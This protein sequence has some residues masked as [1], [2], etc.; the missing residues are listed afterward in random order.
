MREALVIR[1]VFLTLWSER[2]AIKSYLVFKWIHLLELL[3]TLISQAPN[4]TL[5]LILLI[6]EAKFIGTFFHL[7]GMVSKTLFLI[8]RFLHI[9]HQNGRLIQI[10][11]RYQRFR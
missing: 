3:A 7:L 2:F 4:I 10:Q 1:M 6:G 11:R 8:L 5:R 9:F